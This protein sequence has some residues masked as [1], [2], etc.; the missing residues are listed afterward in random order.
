MYQ[1]HLV[2]VNQIMISS[3]QVDFHLE[4]GQGEGGIVWDLQA[5]SPCF[6]FFFWV[7]ENCR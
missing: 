5:T 2:L 3:V 1:C 6:E 7:I 4:K